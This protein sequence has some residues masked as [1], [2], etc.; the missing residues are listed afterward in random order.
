ML[1]EGVARVVN[2]EGESPATRPVA[3]SPWER[4][5]L[6][7]FM[8]S[9]KT[10]VGRLLAARLGWTFI[11][12]DDEVEAATG[13]KVA[14]LFRTRGEEEFRRLEAEVGVAAMK[15]SHTVIAPGGGWSLAAGRMEVLPEGTLTVWL[16]VTPDTAVRRATRHGR[17]RPL[18][19]GPDPVAK[20]KALLDERQS[21]YARARLQLDAETASPASLAQTIASQMEQTK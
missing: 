9:G 3:G 13:I 5:V 4:V 7:G 12:L 15:R 16:K 1:G 17:V 2:A 18:L 6:V 8:G 11:D 14:E 20:A 21:V 10:T 19:L